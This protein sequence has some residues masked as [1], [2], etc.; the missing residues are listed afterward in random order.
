MKKTMIFMCVLLC[1]AGIAFIAG[2]TGDTT[3][4]ETPTPTPTEM[5][6]S[7]VTPGAAETPGL[8]TPEGGTP[9]ETT[10]AESTPTGDGT[11]TA[12]E[13]DIFRTLNAMPEYSVLRE[14]L[15]I[16]G[17]DQTL[18]N[19]G[20]YTLFAPDNSAFSSLPGDVENRIRADPEGLLAPVLL[21][22]VVEGEYTAADLQGMTSLETV[23]GSMLTITV[24]GSDIMVDG[25]LVVEPDIMAT[26]GVIHGIDAVL[27]PPDV[28][29]PA[30]TVEAATTEAT[31][32]ATPEETVNQT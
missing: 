6:T 3:T 19:E 31:T 32:E 28:T 8:G 7:E 13:T 20:P 27:V 26:N 25:A 9:A 12:G 2:C 1:I 16:A 21:Y 30:G 15:L 18:A 5:A 22:H 14:L 4:G 24:S 23:E 11:G 10:T 17:L 29:I